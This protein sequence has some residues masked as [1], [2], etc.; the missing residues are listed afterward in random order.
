M[1]KSTLYQPVGAGK[2]TLSEQVAHQIRDLIARDQLKAGDRLPPMDELTGYLRVS[3]TAVREAVKL[4]D[5]WGIVSVKHGV[6][7]FV[8]EPGGD[9]LRIPIQLSAERGKSAIRNLLQI[10]EALEPDM[11]AIAARNASPENIIAIEQTLHTMDLTLD[12]PAKYVQADLAF[13]SALAEA[14]GNEL[15]LILIHPIIDL[16]QDTMG[17]VQQTP[18]AMMRAQTFHQELVKHIKAGP[19]HAQQARATMIRHLAQ[20]RSDI[21]PHLGAEK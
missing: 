2:G 7:T 10:R 8:A 21:H 5:A 19:G 3:R 12:D 14:T 16:L 4:L 11:A 6:G 17:L 13:H 1:D 9:A 18:G 20:V 15:F